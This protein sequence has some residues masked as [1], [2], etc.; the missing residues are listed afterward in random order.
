MRSGLEDAVAGYWLSAVSPGKPQSQ[1]GPL[2]R[3]AP[4]DRSVT[5]IAAIP[6]SASPSTAIPAVETVPPR[7]VPAAIASPLAATSEE[8]TRKP[9]AWL[10][11]G[12]DRKSV[13]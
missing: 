9:R 1:V 8:L 11:I 13:V 12:S 7:P 4:R 2:T 5:R 3:R 10:V 6:P